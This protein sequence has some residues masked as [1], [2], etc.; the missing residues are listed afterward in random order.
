MTYAKPE[1]QSLGNAGNVIESIQ[2]KMF[3]VNDGGQNNNPAYDLD[4]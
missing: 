4:E 3:S 2:N 1:V